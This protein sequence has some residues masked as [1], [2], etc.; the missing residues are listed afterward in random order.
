MTIVR[1]QL[2]MSS[3]CVVGWSWSGPRSV[4]VHPRWFEEL[5]RDGTILLLDLPELLVFPLA[6]SG[7]Q[8]CEK[9]AY[10]VLFESP[11]TKC[12]V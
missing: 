4:A 3:Q 6:L 12:P 1:S 5:K 7:S 10:L 8:V 11:S 9:I 2:E